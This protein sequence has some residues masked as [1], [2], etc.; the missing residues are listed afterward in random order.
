MESCGSNIL[1]HT[2]RP[3]PP[4][5]TC[6]TS[7]DMVRNIVVLEGASHPQLVDVICDR[8]QVAP[9]LVQLGKFSCGET[10]IEIQESVRGKDVYII[11]SGGGKVNDNFMELLV[12]ISACKTASAQKVTV[13]LPF[14]PYSRQSDVPQKKSGALLSKAS[15][16]SNTP[17]HPRP[18][19]SNALTSTTPHL[20]NGYGPG[21]SNGVER[22]NKNLA[23]A[24]L[25]DTSLP[26]SSPS[27]ARYPEYVNGQ[28]HRSDTND[29]RT[30][31]NSTRHHQGS[32]IGTG[33]MESTM[34]TARQRRATSPPISSL[35]R[36]TR[37]GWHK[38]EL[39]WQIC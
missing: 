8:L 18:Q 32:S 38:Q 11:Q 17:N 4:Q 31:S 36:A 10:R 9:A 12:A 7:T 29:S 2:N 28:R 3:F 33:R 30:S 24:H 5:T 26:A 39:W 1:Q 13:V 23:A 34:T 16:P 35:K 37:S 6:L 27:S 21:L 15:S 19:I 25:E 22:L 20:D 14:F